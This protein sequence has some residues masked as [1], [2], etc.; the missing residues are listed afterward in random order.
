[1]V[2]KSNDYWVADNKI[3]IKVHAASLNPIDLILYNSA[4]PALKWWFG[5]QGIG[6]DYSGVIADIGERAATQTGLKV[7]NEV[8]GLY[9]HPFGKGTV[10]Q[11]IEID[12]NVD[13]SILKKPESLP[14]QHRF[15]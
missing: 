11:Y 7:G 6:R 8:A 3:L 13:K 2:K 12:P 4:Y 10:S 5:E 14:K 1:L 15:R 9:A